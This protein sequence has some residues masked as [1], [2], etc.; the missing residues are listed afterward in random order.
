MLRSIACLTLKDVSFVQSGLLP[1]SGICDRTNDVQLSQHYQIRDH[2]DEGVQGLISVIGVKYTTARDVA[3][4][5]VD[6]V[7]DSWGQKPPKPLSSTTP[8]HG[9]EIERFEHFLRDQIKKQEYRLNEKTV[10]R[11]LYN[12]GS[13]YEDVLR[14]IDNQANGDHAVTNDFAVLKAEVLHG[15]R[16][17]MAQK[18]S[19][20]VLRRTDLGTA[21]YPGNESLNVCANILREEFDWSLTRMQG[22][23]QAVNEFFTIRM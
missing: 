13:A 20:V 17:E 12:Y 19:D 23:V 11:L 21:G 1:S 8:L 16:E 18:L 10:R 4:K 3:E 22:E 5:V 2:R 9:G 7:F 15:I 14:Y 6:H